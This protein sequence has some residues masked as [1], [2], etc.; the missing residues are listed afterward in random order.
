MA[1]FINNTGAL[2]VDSFLANSACCSRS[3]ITKAI[4]LGYVKINDKVCKKS[5]DNLNLEDKVE[6]DDVFF[7]PKSKPTNDLEPNI[8][9]SDESIIVIDKPAGLVV[10]DG[11]GVKE[12]TL[13]DYLINNGYE[14]APICGEN[15]HGI[16]HRLDIG[17]SGV[18]VVAKNDESAL[19]LKKSIISKET[20]KL[21]I[22]IIEQPLKEDVIVDEP[23]GRNPKNRVA[24]KV[25]LDGKPAKTL[26]LKLLESTDKKYELVLAK[27]YSGR[28]HQIRAH[29]NHLGRHIINDSLYGFKSQ[30]D[31]LPSQRVLLHSYILDI[32]HPKKSENLR[33]LAKIPQDFK[34]FL[35]K[36]FTMETMDETISEEYIFDKLNAFISR[37]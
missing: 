24:M 27:I 14:L 10:H 11:D 4:E 36:K 5:S 26:F 20:S 21:Y 9:Y 12:S 16:V 1:Q 30:N 22:A 28:T 29:L 17:T 35:D 13:V 8:I 2:R 37:L 6:I 19:K 25:L 7:V 34:D 15:R 3:K 32:K 31:K 23:I 33:F 18:M